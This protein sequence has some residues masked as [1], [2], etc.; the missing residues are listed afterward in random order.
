MVQR[1][2]AV[3]GV[4]AS[5]G[6]G[7]GGTKGRQRP[8]VVGDLLGDEL[9]AHGA[10]PDER[11]IARISRVRPVPG[12]QLDGVGVDLLHVDDVGF[13]TQMQVARFTTAQ[14]QDLLGQLPRGL[15]MGGV[16]D[17]FA[18]AAEPD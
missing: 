12:R 16:G 7:R 13:V 11:E 4:G 17:D 18:H 15:E 8:T 14:N 3:H 9:A 6:G 2:E 1:G 5:Q 10:E